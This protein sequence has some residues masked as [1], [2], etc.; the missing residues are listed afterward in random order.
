[1]L[2]P[3]ASRTCTFTCDGMTLGGFGVLSPNVRSCSIIARRRGRGTSV[4]FGLAGIGHDG[5]RLEAHRVLVVHVDGL[6][7][8][9]QRVHVVAAERLV[10]L[11]VARARCRRARRARNG[12]L[13][14][15]EIA[16]PAS[17]RMNVCWRGDAVEVGAEVEQAPVLAGVGIDDRPVRDPRSA[18]S[19][20]ARR[21]AR[22]RRRARRTRA[23]TVCRGRSPGRASGPGRYTLHVADGVDDRPGS[24]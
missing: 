6:E 14:L 22:G 19:A 7:R 21:R 10:G 8:A 15:F 20:T 13:R 18:G 11:D 1:M 16:R 4:T 23:R 9:D 24:S 3:V 17:L 5:Q 2:L 12:S